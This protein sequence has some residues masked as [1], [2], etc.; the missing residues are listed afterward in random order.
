MA[1]FRDVKSLQRLA[2]V[3]NHFNRE[4]RLVSR[5]VFNERRA[6]ALAVGRRLAA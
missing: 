6:V 4:R 1:R 2:S 3:H 5:S